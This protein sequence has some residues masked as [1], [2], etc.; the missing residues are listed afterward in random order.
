MEFGYYYHMSCNC[1]RCGSRNLDFAHSIKGGPR[2]AWLRAYKSLKCRDCQERFYGRTVSVDDVRYAH[3]PKCFRMDLNLWSVKHFEPTK[4]QSLWMRFGGKRYRCEY[5]RVNIVSLRK[6]KEIFT[7]RRWERFQVAPREQIG[8]S[9]VAAAGA[10]S[11]G[12][13]LR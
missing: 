11:S 9:M 13:S 5:C 12:L 6:R 3:C 2:F 4:R 8:A 1:P 10:H 7:F